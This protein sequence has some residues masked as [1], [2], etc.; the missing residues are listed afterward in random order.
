MYAR[1]GVVAEAFCLCRHRAG[2]AQAALCYFYYRYDCYYYFLFLS[3][4]T[5]AIFHP[6]EQCQESTRY[7]DRAV[8]LQKPCIVRDDDLTMTVP[9]TM[10]RRRSVTSII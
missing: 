4:R 2:P 6:R 7:A 9:M 3:R 1:I 5:R 10:P 8:G